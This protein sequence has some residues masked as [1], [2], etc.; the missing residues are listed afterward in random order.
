MNT[1]RCFTMLIKGK[2][3]KEE[4]FYYSHNFDFNVNNTSILATEPN[5]DKRFILEITYMQSDN[6]INF[7]TVIQGLSSIDENL[8]SRIRFL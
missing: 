8:I 4:T 2:E 1:C 3:R 5:L 6:S 7:R